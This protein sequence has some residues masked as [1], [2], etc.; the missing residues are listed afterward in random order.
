M[1]YESK[2]SFLRVSSVNTIFKCLSVAREI[3]ANDASKHAKAGTVPR[4]LNESFFLPQQS[5]RTDSKRARPVDIHRSQ[6]I[7]EALQVSFKVRNHGRGK[8]NYFIVEAGF[9]EDCRMSS[10]NVIVSS[11][12]HHP[13]LRSVDMH[14]S[15]SIR[16]TQ[17]G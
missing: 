11:L 16:R 15:Q 9:L 3:V 1:R 14:R 2:S 4:P 7:P 5:A 17:I 10:R 13:E 8:L 12:C 6:S